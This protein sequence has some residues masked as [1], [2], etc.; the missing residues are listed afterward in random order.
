[1]KRIT[2][3][4]ALAAEIAD[5]ARKTFLSLFKNG[6][7]YYYCTLYTTEEGHAPSISAWSREALEVEAAR[8]GDASDKPGSTIAELIKWSY[9]DSRYCCFGDENFDH[10]KLRFVERP[11]ISDLADDEGNREFD[12]RLKAM[13][14]AMKMLDDEGVFALNQPR[15]S[16]CVLVEIMPPDEINTEIALRLN[17]EESPAMQA[18][19]AEAAE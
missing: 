15:E 5:T 19:L 13:E 14:L 3:I 17:W 18:W 11:S 8:Q 6:E 10:V 12:L 2:E 16:V 7:R 4:E 9:A 1:M